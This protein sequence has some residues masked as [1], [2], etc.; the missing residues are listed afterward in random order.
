MLPGER[1]LDELRAELE[2]RGEVRLPVVEHLEG[3]VNHS[4]RVDVDSFTRARDLEDLV[5]E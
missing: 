2:M 5:I 4:A 1:E 3:V